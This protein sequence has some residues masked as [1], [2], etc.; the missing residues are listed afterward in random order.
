[1]TT[2]LP[3]FQP[4]IENKT[5]LEIG[6]PSP[7]LIPTGI[8]T[9]PKSLDNAIYSSQT[10]W[11]KTSDTLQYEFPGKSV[12]GKVI[13]NDITDMKDIPSSTYDFI[14]ASHILEHLVNP[15]KALSEITRVL[16]PY[17]ICILVLP[18][19][20][21]TFDHKRPI[22][23][24][25]KLLINYIQNRSEDTVD[26]YLDEVRNFYDIT[27]DSGIKSITDLVERCK[28]HKSNRALHVHVFDFALIIRCLIFFNYNIIN[29]QLSS[30]YHQFV[31]AQRRG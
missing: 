15:L 26:D 8:Y 7:Y 3:N 17:G 16:K 6:G 21:G 4:L 22:S 5:G 19:K 10:I 13:I 27:R 23:S 29:Y 24:F 20:E 30:P 31:V 11:H 25:N 28:D 9:S 14:V 1:M 12:P 18:W 2:P